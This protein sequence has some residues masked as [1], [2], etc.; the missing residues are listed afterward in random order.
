MESHKIPWF[1]SPPKK[2]A[3]TSINHEKKN[4][5][6]NIRVESLTGSLIPRFHLQ[7]NRLLNPGGSVVG[8]TVSLTMCDVHTNGKRLF[9][10]LQ[11]LQV[12]NTNLHFMYLYS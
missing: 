8:K 6:E 10:D 3:S 11:I 1:Q 12:T 5:T 9:S 2:V 7:L 4:P